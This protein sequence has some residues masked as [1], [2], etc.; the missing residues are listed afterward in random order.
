MT[1]THLC[2]LKILNSIPPFLP[3][4]N[5]SLLKPWPF[6]ALVFSDLGRWI[7]PLVSH[8]PA[9]PPF[10]NTFQKCYSVSILPQRLNDAEPYN[11]L[12]SYVFTSPECSLDYLLSIAMFVKSSFLPNCWNGFLAPLPISFHILSLFKHWVMGFWISQIESWKTERQGNLHKV[13]LLSF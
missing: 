11:L 12:I 5:A 7:L 3:N 8:G 9:V 6:R 13:T 10:S 2:C 1:S 4:A